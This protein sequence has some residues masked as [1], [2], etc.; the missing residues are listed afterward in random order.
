MG[1]EGSGASRAGGEG[2]HNEDAF[3]VEEGLGL[4]VVCDGAG[5]S[6]A[7]ERASRAACAFIDRFFEAGRLDEPD[8]EDAARD[9]VARAMR[10]AIDAVEGAEAGEPAR[11][12]STTLTMLLVHGPLGVIGHRGDS[13]A[14]LVRRRRAQQLTVDHELAGDAGAGAAS[15]DVFTIALLPGDTLVLCTDGA[16]SAVLD[17]AIVRSA[18]DVSP[19]VLASRIASA[20]HRVRP[21][22]DATCVVVRVRADRNAGWLELSRS[23]EATGFGHRVLSARPSPEPPEP[24]D[25]ERRAR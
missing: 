18:Q 11:G 15:F 8:G 12:P 1:T 3:L 17:D 5:S 25:R 19:P 7:G 2:I 21:D 13:R 24:R 9:A 4:Y 20:A 6:P 16:E 10:G 14:Y 23:P 22:Q